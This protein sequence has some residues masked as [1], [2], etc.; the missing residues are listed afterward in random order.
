MAEM[1]RVYREE[2]QLAWSLFEVF[3]FPMHT[4]F[5]DIFYQSSN[6]YRLG[7]IVNVTIYTLLLGRLYTSFRSVIKSRRA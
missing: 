4:L 7:L 6:M 1:G 2:G 5:K 3:R